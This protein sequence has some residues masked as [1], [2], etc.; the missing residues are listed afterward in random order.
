MECGASL[1]LALPQNASA[2]GPAISKTSSIDSLTHN[3]AFRT[4]TAFPLIS[5][6]SSF[7]SMQQKEVLCHLHDYA[8]VLATLSDVGVA[9]ARI[10]LRSRA[11]ITCLPGHAWA[12]TA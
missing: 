3:T 5:A 8:W 1:T 10:G 11:E 7:D 6:S 2:A 12:L 9:L 4:H